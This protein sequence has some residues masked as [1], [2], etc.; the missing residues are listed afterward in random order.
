MSG[1]GLTQ[2][3]H[4][5]ARTLASGWRIAE[6]SGRFPGRSPFL[7]RGDLELTPE[8]AFRGSA[9]FSTDRPKVFADWW[10]QGVVLDAVVEPFA[11]ESLIDASV[12]GVSLTDFGFE[13]AGHQGRGAISYQ[14]DPDGVPVFDADI[15]ADRL[16]ADQAALLARL[17]LGAADG[18]IVSALADDTQIGLRLYAGSLEV[19]DLDASAIVLRAGYQ[20]DALSIDE[21]DVADLAGA[22]I[23]ASGRIAAVSSAPSGT[24]SVQVDAERLDGLASLIETIAP[25]IAALDRF[26]SS[27]DAFA[28][29]ALSLV[30][31]GETIGSGSMSGTRAQVTLDGT[32]G[33]TLVDVDVGLEGRLDDWRA[34]TIDFEAGFTADA[35]D[36]LLRQVGAQVLPLADLGTGRIELGAAGIPEEG[37]DGHARLYM[38]QITLG[39]V[40]TLVLPKNAPPRYTVDAL[41]KADDLVPLAIL[42]GRLP[43]LSSSIGHVD[44]IATLEGEGDTFVMRGLAGTIAGTAIEADLEVDL[45]HDVADLD[46]RIRGRLTTSHVDPAAL[47]DLLLGADQLSGVQD[48]AWSSSAFGPP[49]VIGLD[50][51]LDVT[52]ERVRLAPV[53]DATGVT[54]TL[55]MKSDRLTFDISGAGFSGGRLNG[56]YSVARDGGQAEVILSARVENAALEDLVWRRGGRAVAVGRADVSLDLEGRGRS[57]SGVISSLSGGGTL[58]VRDGEIRALNPRAFDLVIRAADAGLELEDD[59]VRS[60]FASHLD[61]DRLSF[62]ELNASATVTAG[63]MRISNVSLDNQA[64]TVFGN[65]RI[66]LEAGTLDS[67]FS[68][69]VDAGGDA[70]AGAEPEV[71][72]VFS[73]PLTAPRRSID[74]APFTAFLTLRAFEQEVRRIEKLQAE[75]DAQQQEMDKRRLLFERE[76]RREE[77]KQLLPGDLKRPER[78]LR[79]AD[80]AATEPPSTSSSPFE[81]A[82]V[83]APTRAPAPAPSAATPDPSSPA[84]GFRDR[85]RSALDELDGAGGIN[86]ADTPDGR[87]L[88]LLPPLDPPVFIE[89]APDQ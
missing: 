71:G 87:P 62:S 89:I 79:G 6:L 66:D 32:A 74:I 60:A 76:K 21:L 49:L 84:E 33:G 17:F 57:L 85:I 44:L 81:A 77:A 5:E 72:L 65:A 20:G 68:L 69:E 67:D 23:S 52:S 28:P 54:A 1:G 46:P 39:G 55:A 73:G 19:G 82:P 8:P 56:T 14:R 47:A 2:D 7:L 53:P 43:S 75:I 38:D 27:P 18:G 50:L 30:F 10:R 13:V 11:F 61:A 80:G 24:L 59:A 31:D 83:V 58:R 3:I 35:A 4:I 51:A 41:I 88:Q 12:S 34:A 40:G 42:T 36:A 45:R 70:V 78:T 63:V 15:D 26:T 48:G 64:A 25:D 86:P 16:N 9:A 22:R 37:L 29:A